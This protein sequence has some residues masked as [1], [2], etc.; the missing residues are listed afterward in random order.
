MGIYRCRLC[1]KTYAGFFGGEESVN[2][3]AHDI[4]AG[5]NNKNK[6]YAKDIHSCEDGCKGVADFVGIR[7][8]GYGQ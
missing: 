7:G 2:K 5:K 1:G 4:A 3:I 6:L 8:Y